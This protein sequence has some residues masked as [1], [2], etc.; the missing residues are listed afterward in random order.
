M[1]C[2]CCPRRLTGRQ[3]R[4]C[5]PACR[6]AFHTAARRWALKAVEA[7]LVSVETLMALSEPCTDKRTGSDG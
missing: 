4:F 1:N 6:A 3:A 7:G 5:S 2:L